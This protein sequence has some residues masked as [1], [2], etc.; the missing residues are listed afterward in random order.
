MTIRSSEWRGV[1]IYAL[2]LVAI[3]TLP[4]LFAASLQDEDYR[5]S[6]FL[7]G[8]ED[9]NSYLG[10]MRIGA[11]GEWNYAVF[12]TSEQHESAPLVFFPY[13]LTGQIIGAFIPHTSPMLTQALLLTF[14]AARAVFNFLLILVTYRFIAE[15]LRARGTR[16]LALVIA[17]LGGGFGWL[18]LFVG[19]VPPEWF[20][21]EGFTFV[22]LYYLPHIALARAALLWGLLCVLWLMKREPLSISAS[23]AVSL[24]R[25]HLPLQIF[26]GVCWLVVGLNVPFFLTILYAILGAWGLAAWIYARR[27]PTHLFWTVIIPALI[28]LPLFIHFALAF[29]NNLVF[30][31]WTAQNL[32]PSP[33]PIDYALAYSVIAV[34][35]IIG[36]RWAWQARKGKAQIHPVTHQHSLLIGWILIVP[37]LVYLPFIN[38]QR[39]MSE[40]VIVPLAILAAAGV[41]LVARHLKA[42]RR[43]RLGLVLLMLPAYVFLVSAG[44][45]TAVQRRP[46]MFYPTTQISA[47]QWLNEHLTPGDVVL[48]AFSTGNALPAYTDARAFAGHGPETLYALDKTEAIA[49]F[50]NGELTLSELQALYN[51]SHT[52]NPIRFVFYGIQ[53]QRLS[54]GSTIWTVG[55]T[56]VYAEEGVE[57]YA[58]P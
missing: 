27:F 3:T 55:L 36:G 7:V 10:K 15:F 14:H 19:G 34:F 23:C 2:L 26:A 51:S 41:R 35:A 32:L 4:Y 58:V 5:F 28:T 31:Q 53:E 38:V 52:L 43:W 6:G 44:V 54:G 16:F 24:Q 49:R 8:V 42:W 47:F 25:T 46:P 13:I 37:I 29:A 17:T 50:F 30:R 20:I 56:R 9:G 48:S 1:L 21:P 12:Y 18:L 45:F 57:I 39:R 40:A 33:S 11:R 22:I